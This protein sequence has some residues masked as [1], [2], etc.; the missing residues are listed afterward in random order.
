MAQ[1]AQVKDASGANITPN[2]DNA[3][4]TIATY[5]SIPAITANQTLWIR[6]YVSNGDG[7]GT[8]NQNVKIVLNGTDVAVLGGSNTGATQTYFWD[9]FII[10]PTPASSQRV[11]GLVQNIGGALSITNASLAANISSSFT[12]TV[13]GLMN[14]SG[15]PAMNGPW[16]VNAFELNIL[17]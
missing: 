7:H 16:T 4:H 8:G 11:I 13:Q 1:T 14:V 5:A 12:I 9:L 10:V 15:S 3:Y 6:C 17:N 2:A